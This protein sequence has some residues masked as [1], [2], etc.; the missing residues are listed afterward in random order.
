MQIIV[1]RVMIVVLNQRQWCHKNKM[2]GLRAC[3]RYCWLA[4]TCK[5]SAGRS[6]AACTLGAKEPAAKQ[7]TL[8]RQPPGGNTLPPGRRETQTLSPS[9]I[10]GKGRCA[11][12]Q[13]RWSALRPHRAFLFTL[14]CTRSQQKSGAIP[15]FAHAGASVVVS[16]HRLAVVASRRLGAVGG[17]AAVAA[18]LVGA[19]AAF[20]QPG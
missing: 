1:L 20:A 15:A 18:G 11:S 2:I 3:F 19:A 14:R 9:P 4:C 8:S 10:D 17:V 7:V 6:Q 13:A 5:A 16:S 12:R